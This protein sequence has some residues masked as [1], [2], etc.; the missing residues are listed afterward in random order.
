MKNLILAFFLL[1]NLITF[2]QK[3]CVLDADVNDS[4]GTFKSTKQYMIYERS[5]AGNSTNL[6]FALTN[7]NGLLGIETQILQRSNDF[8]KAMCF[9]SNSKIYLQLQNGKI[10]MLLHIGNDDCGTLIRDDTNLNNRILTGTFLFSKENYE[11]LKVAPITF[12]R[13]QF[14]GETI[15]YPFKTNFVSQ[16]D[17]TMY[18]P[19]SYFI[20]YLKCIEN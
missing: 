15:D 14:A 10:V 18:M 8:I 9:D 13:I 20:N 7:T 1:L 6:F 5:F 16:L 3:P 4:I 17:K 11:E 12:M 2:A 19:E